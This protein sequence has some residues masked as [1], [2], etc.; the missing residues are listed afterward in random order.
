[1]ADDM[2]KAEPHIITVVRRLEMMLWFVRGKLPH[3]R[4]RTSI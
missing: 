1:M 2:H 4:R 3:K